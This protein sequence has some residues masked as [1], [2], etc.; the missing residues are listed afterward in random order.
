MASVG[1][2]SRYVRWA[3]LCEGAAVHFSGQG[4]YLR[5]A[6]ARRLHEGDRPAFPPSARDAT[7]LG[8]LY[9]LMAVGLSLGFGVT[10][11]INFAHGEF[12]MLGAYGAFFCAT[13]AGIDPLISLPAVM[14]CR[15]TERSRTMLA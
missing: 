9:C 1:S 12:I 10:R 3:W 4:S 6:V 2:F 15:S 14:S 11:I 5:A 13:L 8:G 7:L